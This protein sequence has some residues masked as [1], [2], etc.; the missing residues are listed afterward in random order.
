MAKIP[1]Q[2]RKARIISVLMNGLLGQGKVRDTYRGRN[3][4][5][6]LVV[7]SD[8]LSIFD[9]VLNALIFMK[10]VRL[11]RITKFWFTRVLKD[12]P[13]HFIFCKD[14]PLENAAVDLPQELGLPIERSMLVKM[15]E[16]LSYELIFRFHLGGSVYK[17]YLATGMVAGIQLP[18]GIAKWSKLDEPL[19]TPSTK[20]PD[21]HDINITQEEF[22][23][24]TGEA[25]REAVELGLKACK[26]AYAYAKA[27]GILILDTKME[28][29]IL[30]DG[31]VILVDEVFT[32]DSSRFV[33]ESEWLAAMAAG[34]DPEFYD[35]ERVRI[36]G[37]T[38]E[39]P[40]FDQD[41]KQITGID[42]LDPKD[43]EHVAFVHSLIVPEE[44]LDDT[45]ERYREIEEALINN[46]PLAV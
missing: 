39:T 40:F 31:T 43:E 22:F 7:A 46:T 38:V 16:V 18:P 29:G 25:G 3:E 28:F 9:F 20:A 44:V 15:A 30:P 27:L 32:P 2:I 26:L 10:G 14:D 41:G 21:G 24:A 19:F 13:N 4:D 11:T 8:S 42:N 6:L 33:K 5:E 45:S 35:K 12:I 34:R 36:W 23:S 1:E 17:K 37:R